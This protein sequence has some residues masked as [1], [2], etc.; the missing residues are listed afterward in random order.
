MK[1]CQ[2]LCLALKVVILVRKSEVRVLTRLFG[3][4]VEQ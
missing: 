3:L 2:N 1:V 4:R